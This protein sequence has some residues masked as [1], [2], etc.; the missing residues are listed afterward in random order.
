[1]KEWKLNLQS[2]KLWDKN[3]CTIITSGKKLKI[4]YNLNKK[5]ARS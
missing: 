2:A 1:M 3:W 4:Y 5:T